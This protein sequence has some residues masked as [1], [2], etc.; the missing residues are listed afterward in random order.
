MPGRPQ[1]AFLRTRHPENL[2]GRDIGPVA[3]VTTELVLKP[4]MG[5]R[6]DGAL[7]Y[8]SGHQTDTFTLVAIVVMLLISPP[9]GHPAP[10]LRLALATAA[11]LAGCAVAMSLV[12][13]QRHY[14]SDTIAGAGNRHRGG[15][16]HRAPAGPA[17]HA[18][19]AGWCSVD[20][21]KAEGNREKTALKMAEA[22]AGEEVRHHGGQQPAYGRRQPA[23]R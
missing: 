20:R 17:A 12:A 5:E 9:G 11:V 16:V 14:L 13:I 2:A 10:W 19:Q 1:D 6:L 18:A 4:P 7:T 8:L 3:I 23:G 22:G 21:E 15:P